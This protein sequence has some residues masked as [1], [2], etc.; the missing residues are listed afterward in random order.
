VKFGEGRIS[1]V[2]GSESFERSLV[3]RLRED[4]SPPKSEDKAN[5]DAEREEASGEL[6]LLRWNT[7]L[8]GDGLYGVYC[9]NGRI[10]EEA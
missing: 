6:S 1:S 4:L 3:E 7:A 9:L 5:G 2:S 10:T 8:K